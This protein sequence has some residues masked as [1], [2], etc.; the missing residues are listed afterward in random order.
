MDESYRG[1]VDSPVAQRCGYCAS[2][3]SLLGCLVSYSPLAARLFPASMMAH[4]DKLD[5]YR[6][7]LT[8]RHR[9]GGASLV[10][11]ERPRPDR[12][13]IIDALREDHLEARPVFGEGPGALARDDGAL[14]GPRDDR[15]VLQRNNKF[16]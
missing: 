4:T 14:E 11:P 5:K 6:R 12:L 2:W 13:L 15:V 9:R 3:P 10:G 1:A 16:L 7:E 8:I